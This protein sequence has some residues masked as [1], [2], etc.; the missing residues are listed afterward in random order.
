MATPNPKTVAVPPINKRRRIPKRA[1]DDVVRQIAEKFQPEKIILFGSYA[2][3]NPTQVSDVD[4][5]VIMKTRLRESQQ[6]IHIL[7]SIDFH[8]GLDL[9]VKTPKTLKAR[10]GLGD[11]FLKEIVSKGKVVYERPVR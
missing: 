11:F 7:N 1:I 10:I 6:E 4:L 8:F 2:Y 3:G 5:L 9:L